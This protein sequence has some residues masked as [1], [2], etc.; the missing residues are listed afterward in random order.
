MLSRGFLGIVDG[1]D[2]SMRRSLA[3]TSSLVGS[4]LTTGIH[5]A[6]DCGAR[7]VFSAQLPK[8]PFHRR[9]EYNDVADTCPT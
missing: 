4:G 9:I 5:T 7:Y 3:L 1:D 8:T 2:R 6:C